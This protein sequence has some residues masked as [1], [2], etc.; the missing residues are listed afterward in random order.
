MKDDETSSVNAEPHVVLGVC[1]FA[2]KHVSKIIP[3]QASLS[4][5][6]PAFSCDLGRLHGSVVL[7][8][9]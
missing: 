8:G 2:V 6:V 5:C 3:S 7:L 9:K 4:H 1:L